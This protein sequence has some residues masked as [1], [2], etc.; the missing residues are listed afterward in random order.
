MGKSRS[1]AIV[2]LIMMFTVIFLAM[3]PPVISSNSTNRASLYGTAINNYPYQADWTTRTY[4]EDYVTQYFRVGYSGLNHMDQRFSG[5]ET[6]WDPNPGG[7]TDPSTHKALCNRG[8]S[9]VYHVNDTAQNAYDRINNDCMFVFFGHSDR[10][11]LGF[12]G[13]GYLCDQPNLGHELGTPTYYLS[14]RNDLDDMKF[15]LLLGCSTSDGGTSQNITWY[16]RCINKVDTVIGFDDDTVFRTAPT[17]CDGTPRI[18]YPSHVWNQ[19]FWYYTQGPTAYSIGNAEGM[20]D[21]Q[22]WNHCANQYWG[23]DSSEV[24]GHPG[25]YINVPGNGL[26]NY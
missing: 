22:V 6:Y 14:N 18:F 4:H 17:M 20:A 9:S 3:S 1:S 12:R 11:N 2:M 25:D 5:I 23:L 26:I 15:A 8:W 10:W 16:M 19:C 7:W 21:G 13:G 24:W